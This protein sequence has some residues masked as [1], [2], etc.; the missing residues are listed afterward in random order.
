MRTGDGLRSAVKQLSAWRAAASERREAAPTDREC[1]RLASLATVG[2][3]IAN[4]ALRREE[5]RGGHFRSDFP[6]RDDIHFQKHFAD[7][8]RP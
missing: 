8:L 3:L 2:F 6:Q 4:A 7:A 1:R 5:T